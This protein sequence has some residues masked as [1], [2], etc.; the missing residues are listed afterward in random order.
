MTRRGARTSNVAGKALTPLLLEVLA[1][2]NGGA[3]LRTNRALL[4]DNARAAAEVACCLAVE[5]VHDAV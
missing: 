3:T 2:S 4:A 1:E 5:R